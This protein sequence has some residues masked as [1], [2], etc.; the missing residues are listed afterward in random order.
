MIRRATPDDALAI[1]TLYH[2][3]ILRINS[4]GYA[5]SQILAWAG[6]TLDE[7]KW[8][9]RQT[10][11]MTF[12]DEHNGTLRGFAEVEENGHIGAVYV[13]ADCQGEGIASLLLDEMKKEAVARGVTCLS[14]EASITAQP[15][16]ARHGFETIAAQDVEYAGQTFRNYRMRADRSNRAIS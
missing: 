13:H 6:A 3:T 16:F 12:V 11:R 7:K 14:T 10:H 8:R 2:D 1:A 4:R 9:E 15:F 5:P